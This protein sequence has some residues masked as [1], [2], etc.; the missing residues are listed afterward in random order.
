MH[1]VIVR[2]DQG[3]ESVD[4]SRGAAFENVP[5]DIPGLVAVVVDAKKAIPP[6]PNVDLRL[7]RA[8]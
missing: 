4:V 5:V 6:C 3:L 8:R 2:C 7:L 1:T